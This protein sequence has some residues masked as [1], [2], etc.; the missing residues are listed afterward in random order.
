VALTDVTW[1]GKAFFAL[2]SRY[3]SDEGSEGPI[4]VVTWS[5]VD[6]TAWRE[7]GSFQLDG[8]EDDCPVARS[9]AGNPD[10][11][12]IGGTVTTLDL[13]GPYRSAD[14][15]TWTRIQPSPYG[16]DRTH[17][18]AVDALATG[19]EI[20]LAGACRGCPAVV[21]RSRNGVKWSR[22]GST[23]KENLVGVSLAYDGR[24]FVVAGAACGGE[25]GTKLWSAV[26]GLPVEEVAAMDVSRAQVTFTGTVFMLVG[27]TN[28]GS[29]V[30]VS[31]DGVTW[32][33]Q[34]TD[35]DRPP[36]QIGSLVSG[37]AGVLI[38]DI[39]CPGVWLSPAT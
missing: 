22:V 38:V 10:V 9:L 37:P 20:F 11:L 30:Y 19:D 6:G 13:A 36:C 3:A 12:V 15:L 16:T 1:N 4:D 26:E 21:V 8:C 32:K 24:R 14:G 7:I 18:F 31:P 34:R 29:R 33:E 35:L 28:Q 39:G 5:S 17:Y 27:G 2:G 25:C 23:E